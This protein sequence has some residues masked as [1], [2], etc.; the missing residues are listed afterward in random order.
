MSS[1]ESPRQNEPVSAV[2]L[3]TFE[4]EIL[5]AI[6]ELEVSSQE[7]YGLGIKRE[8]EAVLDEDINHGRLYPNLDNLVSK[9][10]IEKSELDK[11]TNLYHLTNTGKDL[12]QDYDDRLSDIANKI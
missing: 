3:L 11:R 10:L 1:S 8:L 7:S 12:I 2:D 9:G 6:A 5:Y 4:K